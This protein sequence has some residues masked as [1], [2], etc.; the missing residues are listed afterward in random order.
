[1]EKRLFE[2]L[3]RSVELLLRYGATPGLTTLEDVDAFNGGL[4]CAWIAQRLRL[5]IAKHPEYL[6]SPKP[7]AA[8]AQTDRVDVAGIFCFDLG[9]SP[10]VE[11][12]A[13]PGASSAILRRTTIR[14]EWRS[15]CWI[16]GPKWISSRRCTTAVRCGGRCG[17]KA[18]HGGDFEPGGRERGGA[19]GGGK[20]ERCA[21][22]CRRSRGWRRSLTRARRRCSGCRMM[23]ASASAIVELFLA[24]G[25]DP[26]LKDK[27][28]LTAAVGRAN[29]GWKEAA[30]LLRAA[31]N[32]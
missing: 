27:E 20:V 10:D 31:A 24:H 29:A 19:S 3:L 13:G 2:A 28:G 25:A 18:A 5:G 22:C 9:M 4:V 11:I 23:R 7:I 21:R 17:T 8:A 26:A 6:Q 16:A 1:M 14:R 32:R 15:S 30:R 12:H